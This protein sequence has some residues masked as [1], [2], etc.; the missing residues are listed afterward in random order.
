GEEA[1]RRLSQMTHL[2][3]Q[4][5]RRLAAVVGTCLLVGGSGA[6]AVASLGPDPSDLPVQIVLHDIQ[7]LSAQQAPEALEAQQFH[8]FRLYRSDTVR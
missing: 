4:H 1:A 2:V 8:R 7:P 5:P 6:F 3:Q